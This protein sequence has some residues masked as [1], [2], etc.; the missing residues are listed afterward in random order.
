[1][2]SAGTWS[3]KI[4]VEKVSMHRLYS[5]RYR[6]ADLPLSNYLFSLR[7]I[8]WG[9]EI[10]VHPPPSFTFKKIKNL[11]QSE[12]SLRCRCIF[13]IVK[14]RTRIYHFLIKYPTSNFHLR[15]AGFKQKLE[16]LWGTVWSRFPNKYPTEVL[17]MFM[18]RHSNYM[19]R[20]ECRGQHQLTSPM[21]D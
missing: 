6:A 16:G 10:W 20:K 18:H 11:Q 1:M 3:A 17:Q 13:G 12:Y 19:C 4:G 9:Y 21:E 5:K 15:I 2:H 14:C 8:W 7:N